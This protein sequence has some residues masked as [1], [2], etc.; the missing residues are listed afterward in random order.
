MHIT[1]TVAIFYCLRQGLRSEVIHHM[2]TASA[3]GLC[4]AK[5]RG[6]ETR[7]T[8]DF[9]SVPYTIHCTGS[10]FNLGIGSSPGTLAHGDG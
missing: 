10:L 1:S 4:R 2:T 5:R 9:L 8:R 7:S 3:S 6:F